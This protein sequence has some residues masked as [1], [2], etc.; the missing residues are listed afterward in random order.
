MV[1]LDHLTSIS[2][3]PNL[4]NSTDVDAI[5]ELSEIYPD[6]VSSAHDSIGLIKSDKDT[7][8]YGFKLSIPTGI[9][10]Y[11]YF[12]GNLGKNVLF[13]HLNKYKFLYFNNNVMTNEILSFESPPLI[14]PSID[15]LCQLATEVTGN[16]DTSS[17]REVLKMLEPDEFGDYEISTAD[18]SVIN[19]S[20][21]IG[22]HKTSCSISEEVLKYYGTRS[23]TK[24][25]QNI[26]GVSSLV[27]N[28]IVDSDNNLVEIVIEFNST[29]LVKE[30]GYALSTRF[31]YD[32]PEGSTPQDN[33]GVYLDRHESH[34]TSVSNISSSVKNWYWMSEEWEK[35]IVLWE[36]QPKA[37]HGA[38]IITAGHDG[39]KLELVYGLD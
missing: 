5:R 2:T 1:N 3:Y 17:L 27:D 22:L 30:I 25:Y 29:G 35:E 18:I 14:D 36:Q 21:R 8:K 15:A 39:T 32:A 33:F 16:T 9:E 37:V 28:L 20:I 34:K 7:P 23:N 11:E 26:E 12:N 24:T 19:K 13:K 10:D 38:T 4:F 6:V 31:S